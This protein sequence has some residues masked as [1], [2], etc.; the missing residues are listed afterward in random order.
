MLKKYFLPFLISTIT[1]FVTCSDKIV[2]PN[3]F[4]PLTSAE[5][6]VVSSSEDFGFKLFNKINEFEGEKNIFISPLSISMA[7]GMALN[8]AAGT[9]YDA[10]Q[11]TLELSSLSNQEINESYKSLIELLT[12]I[13]PRVTFQIANSIWYENSMT[14]EKEFIDLN[15]KYFN[16]EVA[17]LNFGDP[18]SVKTINNWVSENTNRKIEGILDFIPPEAIMYLINAIYFKGTWQYEFNK[19]YTKDD[20][21]N[22]P[23]GEKVNCKMM[24]QTNEKFKYYSNSNF[25]AVDLPYGNGYFS[26]TIFLPNFDKSEETILEQLNKENWELWLNNFTETEGT[27]QLPKFELEYEF[28]LNDVL[29]ALGMQIA[30][31]PMNA[32]FTNLYKPGAVY[33]SEVKHKTYVK[34][35]EEG[36]EAAA[37]TSVEFSRTSVGDNSFFMR[38]N[39]PFIF[40]IRESNSGSILFM[41]K[42]INPN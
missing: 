14:F 29:Q 11:S 40:I 39:R 9:T 1:F 5:K 3:E 41:G 8:G 18:N 30:F 4:R 19:E 42:I 37:V 15:K 2:E 17:G 12:Q 21:F 28:K 35:D 7:L 24:A 13:D 23:N 20:F 22:L 10:M 33:I 25:E 31:D 27:I 34:V 6:K 32:D 36:T 16:A 26:M 38:V